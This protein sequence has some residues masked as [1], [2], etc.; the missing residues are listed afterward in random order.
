MSPDDSM[1]LTHA[2][3]DVGGTL[4]V[5][6]GLGAA[7]ASVLEAAGIEISARTAAVRHRRFTEGVDVPD[8][9]TRDDWMIHNRALLTALGAPDD[10]E[11]A[12]AVFE[13]LRSIEWQPAI[14]IDTLRRLDVPVGIVSNW[15]G[16]IEH[17]IRELLP[18]DPLCIVGSAHH[19]LRKP[20]PAIYL[21]ACDLLETTP[22]RVAMVGDS[23]RLD[24]EPARA[25]GMTTVLIDDLDVFPD[26]PGVRVQRL[27][28]AV[29][30]LRLAASR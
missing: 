9:P 20:D 21:R 18:V 22:D 30:F 15:D 14:G 28:E 10:H 3:F 13:A 16:T 7:L 19:G 1:Q 4:L 2:L 8:A 5:K 6:P 23:P 25:L 12:A 27:D 17:R 29:E 26:A 11:L 24:I